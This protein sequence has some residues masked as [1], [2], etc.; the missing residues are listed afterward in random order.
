[1]TLL[2]RPHRMHEMQTIAIVFL[3]SGVFVSRSVHLCRA[4]MAE[5]I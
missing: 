2:F 3:W 5:Q 1:M 4:K